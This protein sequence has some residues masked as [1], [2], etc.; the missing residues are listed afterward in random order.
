M[1]RRRKH[2]SSVFEKIDMH[3]ADRE[4]CWE[5]RGSLGGRDKR[6]YAQVDGKRQLVYRVVYTLVVGPISSSE[7]IRHKCDNKL[8][9][10]PYH[11]EK[12]THQQNMND[13]KERERHGLPHHTVRAIKKLLSE[14]VTHTEIA[15]RYGVSR[16]LVTEINRGKVYDHVDVEMSTDEEGNEL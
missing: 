10:N 1:P 2:A 6:P 13:M 3:G 15:K 11:L 16:Q 12:G 14:H 7:V 9:C 5:W 4:V 8:C